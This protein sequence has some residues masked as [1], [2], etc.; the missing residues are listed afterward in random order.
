MLF[1]DFH[2]RAGIQGMAG[3]HIWR[4]KVLEVVGFVTSRLIGRMNVN[5]ST[6]ET[7]EADRMAHVE[8][9]AWTRRPLS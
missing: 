3:H 4:M 1:A 6:N 5:V 9:L 8:S 2:L 7:M